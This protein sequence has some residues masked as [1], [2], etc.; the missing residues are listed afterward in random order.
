MWVAG[1]LGLIINRLVFTWA[2]SAGWRGDGTDG[3]S[4]AF[5]VV[6]F[7]QYGVWQPT[8]AVKASLTADRTLWNN[9]YAGQRT[10]YQGAAGR[11]LPGIVYE[12]A[13]PGCAWAHFVKT[14]WPAAH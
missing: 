8:Y 14:Q 3:T 6:M 1:C 9:P 13:E 12:A 11:Q 5:P 7:I 10:L 4:K 2:L